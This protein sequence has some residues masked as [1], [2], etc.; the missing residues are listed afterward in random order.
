MGFH[1]IK[2]NNINKTLGLKKGIGTVNFPK[3]FVHTDGYFN[4]DFHKNQAAD[5]WQG[6]PLDHTH[7]P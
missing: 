2:K 4:Q 7:S 6:T 5:T 1:E 3:F